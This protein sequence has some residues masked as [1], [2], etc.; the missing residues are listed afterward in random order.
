VKALRAFNNR[1]ECTF[2]GASQ[3]VA[4]LQQK[5]RHFLRCPNADKT[6]SRG[7]VGRLMYC[8]EDVFAVLGCYTPY[9]GSCLQT[10]RDNLSG[11][12][13]RS[14]RR[15]RMPGGCSGGGVEGEQANVIRS[16]GK[17]KRETPE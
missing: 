15:R 2:K 7:V 11:H 9:V 12:L 8:E 5:H 4:V 16:W 6:L 1:G 13:K 3:N 10:F 17:W 14:K